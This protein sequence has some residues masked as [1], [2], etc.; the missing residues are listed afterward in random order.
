MGNNHDGQ[1][2]GEVRSQG[3]PAEGGNYGST[4]NHEQVWKDEPL[5]TKEAQ[6]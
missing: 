2:T 4:F 5:N 6:G 1:V 3:L